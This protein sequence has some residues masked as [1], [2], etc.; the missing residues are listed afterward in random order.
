MSLVNYP[1]FKSSN[2]YRNDSEGN[3]IL[4][5]CAKSY[6]RTLGDKRF[7]LNNHLASVLSI[8]SD[9]KLQLNYN[10]DALVDA[11]KSE[12]LETHDT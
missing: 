7:E 10:G 9:R 5:P 8:V 1:I 4:M 12:I 3:P 2:S 11:Y 6:T